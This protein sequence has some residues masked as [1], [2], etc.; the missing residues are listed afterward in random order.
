MD[1]RPS[2]CHYAFPPLFTI[3]DLLSKSFASSTDSAV[4]AVV[5]NWKQV[6]AMDVPENTPLGQ[7]QRKHGKFVSLS[8]LAAALITLSL[9][10]TFTF[11][12][13]YIVVRPRVAEQ[14]TTTTSKKIVRNEQFYVLRINGVYKEVQT[15]KII[16]VKDGSNI[17]GLEPGEI[18]AE[19]M[20]RGEVLVV[21]LEVEET[22]HQTNYKWRFT[23]DIWLVLGAAVLDFVLVLGAVLAS[24]EAISVGPGAFTAGVYAGQGSIMLHLNMVLRF[25]CI[26]IIGVVLVGIAIVVACYLAYLVLYMMGGCSDS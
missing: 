26:P 1:G 14:Y 16:E 22:Q 9:I 10:F 17:R 25:I 11:F 5:S 2:E 18:T 13:L 4:N 24:T 3:E 19:L 7:Y 21:T 15:G 23:K 20:A 6:L 12:I 8:R